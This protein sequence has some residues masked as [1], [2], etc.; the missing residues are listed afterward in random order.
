MDG[1]CRF[2]RAGRLDGAFVPDVQRFR[3]DYFLPGAQLGETRS[4]Y[5]DLMSDFV[6]VHKNISALVENFGKGAEKS[7]KTLTNI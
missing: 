1:V 5:V 2:G 6:T 3:P 7:L 4:A